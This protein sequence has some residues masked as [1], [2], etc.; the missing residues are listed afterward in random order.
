M[1]ILAQNYKT[2][3]LEMLE[4]P[5]MTSIKGLL[6][7]TVASLV[8]VGTEKA[9][10]EVAQKS[11]LGKA[12]ARP[13]WVRQVIDKIKT[14]GLMEAWHQSQAWL[15]TPV[16]LGYSCA[17]IVTN[18]GTDI[19]ATGFSLG[20]RVACS[21]S[22]HASHA[23][24]NVVPPNLCVKIP[25][26]VSFEDASYVALGGIALEAVRLAKVELGYRVGVIGLGLLGQLAVQILRAAGCHVFGVDVVPE[27]CD[28]A[29]RNGAEAVGLIG[30]TDPITFAQEFSNFEGLDAVIIFASVDSDQPLIQAA[31][32]CRERGK[33]VAGGLVRLHI[34][35]ELFYKK[36][37]EFAVS[38]AW[39]PGMYD[40][41]FEE[42]GLKYPLAYA[43]WTAQR[44][45][46][47]FLTLV[48]LGSV[49][50]N[51][52]TT[53][54]FPF[55]KALEAYQMILGQDIDAVGV[56]LQYDP[57]AEVQTQRMMA[58]GSD[59][60]SVSGRGKNWLGAQKATLTNIHHLITNTIFKIKTN[61]KTI[62]DT[63]T[64]PAPIGIGLIGAGMFA[65]GTI[66]P[67]LKKIKEVAYSG[68]ATAS[69]LS[70][71]HIAK[72]YKFDYATTDYHTLLADP[73]VKL[74]FIL[75]RHDSHAHLVCEALKAG[76]AV[77][78][79]KP[80]CIAK[81]QLTDIIAAYTSFSSSF[82]M[83]GFN[84]RF[85]PATKQCANFLGP[86]R[87]SSVVQIRCNAGFIPPESWVHK[88]DEG[89]GRIIG[90][91]CHFVDLAQAITGG[92]PQ[93]VFA[94]AS[95]SPQTLRDNLVISLKMSNGAVAG[96]TYASN[97][98][99][100][101]PREE[102]QVFAGGSVCVI[103]NFRTIRFVS[104]GKKTVHRVLRVDR[105]H[106][107]EL[108]STIAA[109]TLNEPS[110]IDFKSL[111]AA[112]LAT[113]AIEESLSTGEAIDINLGAWGIH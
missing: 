104:A 48:S 88:R 46:E 98:D 35:R 81:N 44:N 67:E 27:R 49:K 77:F 111:V 60:D 59:G 99:K 8:S 47:E 72:K 92:L 56:V 94:S 106:G 90:E 110:P 1:K 102:V 82:L 23:E 55:E 40:P 66:L 21:G 103:D 80:L 58:G 25:E 45:M 54:R 52:I 6:V 26:N 33:I 12:L 24:F 75:T 62:T 9:M 84:R 73:N 31:G 63:E 112:T 17:G 97:G 16:P 68:I 51:T 15:D 96:I 30:S 76:K 10:I 53:H 108:Q 89:G 64:V 74:V 5:M 71:H 101:F 13:D 39:G 70:G 41:D 42:R 61:T 36:E 2:G 69:G 37:L 65:R 85:A 11:L 28:R 22:G 34:P 19:S 113:F 83:V 7:K 18:S 100:S 93:R 91:V 105:G 20:D 57:N 4:V 87:A 43:R 32:M 109:L 78:V 29:Y 14:E 79:E 38:R 95:E 107:D 86:S 50:L 3:E